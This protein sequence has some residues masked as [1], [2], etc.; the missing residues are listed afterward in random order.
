MSTQT[1]VIKGAEMLTT[2]GLY[3]VGTSKALIR[4]ARDGSWAL[5]AHCGSVMLTELSFCV[6]DA[7]AH[8]LVSR[9]IESHSTCKPR[10]VVRR[11][12]EAAMVR[13]RKEG[14]RVDVRISTI[15]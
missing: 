11:R 1:Q 6:S 4:V 12:I 14:A 10:I 5:C 8:E 13:Y 9:W 3:Q 7:Q 15:W 2:S